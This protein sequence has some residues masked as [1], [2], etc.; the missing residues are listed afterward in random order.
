MVS[1]VSFYKKKKK[2]SVQ[3][4]HTSFFG[5]YRGLMFRRAKKAP[6]LHFDFVKAGRHAIHSYFV[7]F[8]FVA[9][10]LDS[11]NKIISCELIRP[12][13]TLIVS[14]AKTTTLIEI[15]CTSKNHTLIR[16]IV[17]KKLSSRSRKI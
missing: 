6:I 16:G 7:F 10:W 15:P 2:I 11:K 12:F 17:D 4:E 5:K 13:R 3:A 8:D 1:T 14:P 9:V